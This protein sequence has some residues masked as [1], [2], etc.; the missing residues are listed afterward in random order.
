MN[1]ATKY[2]PHDL[3]PQIAAKLKELMHRLGLVYGAID[4]R[5]TPEG[6]YVFLEINPAGQFL[7]IEYATGHPIA[8]ALA[9]AL[10]E[11]PLNKPVAAGGR[12]PRKRVRKKVPVAVDA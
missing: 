3:P 7:Y 8:A 5:L 9:R 11:K 1:L 10:I 6:Q 2:E 12:P 4:L